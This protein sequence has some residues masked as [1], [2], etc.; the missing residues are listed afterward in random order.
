MRFNHPDLVFLF[1]L[2]PLLL[3]LL[4]YQGRRRKKA[5][6]ALADAEL[7]GRLMPNRS[8]WRLLL[9]NTLKVAALCFLV[10]AL[11]EPQWG[12]KEE[13][14]T[15][16]GA[17]LMLVM[18]VSNSM[19]AQDIKPS[20]LERMK[21]KL[22]DLLEILA[23]D[24]VGLI[25]FAGRSFLLS[26]LTID[27]GTLE[28]FIDE[29]TPQT[30]PVQG[31]DL[32]GALSLAIKA[33]N[34]KDSAKAIMV[35]SDGED[36]S[37]KLD[38]MIDVLKEKKIKIFALGFG[39]AEG[40]PIPESGGGFKTNSDGQMVVS[41]LKEEALKD[42]ALQ[43]GGAYVR[44]VTGDEDLKRLYVKGVRGALELSELKAARKQVWESRFYWPL[45]L[46]LALLVLER[47]VS[48][49]KRTKKKLN[50]ANGY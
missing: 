40:A 36:F 15:M 4:L 3:A 45:G 5:W 20:R 31:T 2:V 18:D 46:A 26:P 33:M 16:K 34:D 6:R 28:M 11:M 12:M 25:A 17:D 38:K 35:F 41:K 37:E 22:R 29:L 7:Q 43:T 44:A 23:G 9:K 21:R 27:Y 8:P 42:L 50:F 24:R 1:F 19:L 30:I 32:S 10:L 13:E 48:D 47:L 14:V 49:S 39:T